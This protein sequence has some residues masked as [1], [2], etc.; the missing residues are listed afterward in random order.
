MSLL[1]SYFRTQINPDIVDPLSNKEI[2]EILKEYG[3]DLNCTGLLK[4][5]LISFLSDNFDYELLNAYIKNNFE[6]NYW[7]VRDACWFGNYELIKC[8]LELGYD[9]SITTDLSDIYGYECYESAITSVIKS[10]HYQN[11]DDKIKVLDLL[12]NY[13]ANIRENNDYPLQLAIENN[14]IILLEYLLE[15]GI[16]APSKMQFV[17]S[18]ECFVLLI[19]YGFKWDNYVETIMKIAILKNSTCPNL[20][21]V[22]LMLE[23]GV[24]PFDYIDIIKSVMRISN[25]EILKMFYEF[26]NPTKLTINDWNNLIDDTE[27]S[28]EMVE[29]IL[30]DE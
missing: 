7:S 4:F 3:I 10:Y 13:G 18:Y 6:F 2:I 14:D 23:L 12:Q 28:L 27:C 19:Q 22:K 29:F 8:L 26:G 9:P 30:G 17:E 11:S 16:C 25:M 20:D 5:D 24:D 15:L 21:W 1:K